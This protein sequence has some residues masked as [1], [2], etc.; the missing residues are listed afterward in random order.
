MNYHIVDKQKVL[1]YLRM[2]I[3]ER[4]T[5]PLMACAVSKWKEDK[6]FVLQYQL[7]Q[8]PKVNIARLEYK[9]T[10]YYLQSENK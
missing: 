7:E 10:N 2:F 5:N 4:E 8:H 9:S 3:R 6:E 1:D